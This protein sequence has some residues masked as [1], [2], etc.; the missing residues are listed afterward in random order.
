MMLV[1][2]HARVRVKLLQEFRR[3]SSALLLLPQAT[4]RWLAQQ[5]A[6]SGKKMR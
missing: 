1:G 2:I 4:R 5:H 6:T 3:L